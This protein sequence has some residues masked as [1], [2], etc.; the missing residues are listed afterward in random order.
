MTV[1][2]IFCARDAPIEGVG[3]VISAENYDDARMESEWC[4]AAF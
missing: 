1:G 2:R 4:G 3:V